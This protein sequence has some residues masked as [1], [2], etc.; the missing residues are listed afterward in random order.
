MICCQFLFLHACPTFY[1]NSGVL[2]HLTIRKQIF[3]S[4]RCFRAATIPNMNTGSRVH[5]ISTWAHLSGAQPRLEILQGGGSILVSAFVSSA[6]AGT[7][8]PFLGTV[9]VLAGGNRTRK[10]SP[11]DE[12]D[13]GGDRVV[14]DYGALSVHSTEWCTRMCTVG[15][16]R[17]AAVSVWFLI[18]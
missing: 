2:L 1:P 13:D 18:I 5:R 6:G 8:K 3:A 11:Y 9:W 15:M 4:W 16:L 10:V 14:C 17:G 12:Y 7:S